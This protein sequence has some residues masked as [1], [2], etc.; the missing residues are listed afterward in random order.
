MRDEYLQKK[1]S[2]YN[3]SESNHLCSTIPS[4]WRAEYNNDFYFATMILRFGIKNTK[5]CSV[6]KPEVLLQRRS[7]FIKS[8]GQGSIL[9]TNFDFHWLIYSIKVT[10]CMWNC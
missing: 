6:I 1:I 4:T 8:N 10:V 2:L 7:S 9:G 3:P 5:D